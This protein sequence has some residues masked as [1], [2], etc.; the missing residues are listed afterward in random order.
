MRSYCSHTRAHARLLHVIRI[1]AGSVSHR[2]LCRA[3]S[4]RGFSS[5]YNESSVHALHLSGLSA[6]SDTGTTSPRCNH[7]TDSSAVQST[8]THFLSP[9]NFRLFG[10]PK[11]RSK[12]AQWRVENRIVPDLSSTCNLSVTRSPRRCARCPARSSLQAW[13]G[14]DKGGCIA[15]PSNAPGILYRQ[16]RRSNNHIILIYC[17]CNLLLKTFKRTDNNLLSRAPK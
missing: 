17:T 7:N 1:R 3:P 9:S 11:M 8:L 5:P 10:H 16:P 12:S 4:E 13:R 6:R 14:F 15:L 2:I